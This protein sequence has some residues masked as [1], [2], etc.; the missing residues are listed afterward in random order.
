LA[1]GISFSYV[2]IEDNTLV[3]Q[4]RSADSVHQYSSTKSALRGSFL[5]SLIVTGV[6]KH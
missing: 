5:V 1:R 6:A 3:T 4:A 2:N